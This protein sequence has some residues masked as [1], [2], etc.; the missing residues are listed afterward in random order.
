M[1]VARRGRLVEQQLT[2]VR[3]P[4][5]VDTVVQHDALAGLVLHWDGCRHTRDQIEVL[6]VADRSNVTRIES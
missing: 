6:R 2:V 3:V 5:I 1:H 4:T